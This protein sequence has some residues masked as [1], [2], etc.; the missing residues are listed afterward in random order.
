MQ[1]VAEPYFPKETGTRKESKNRMNPS[2][3]KGSGN[4]RK[5]QVDPFFKPVAWTLKLLGL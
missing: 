4:E 5:S 3:K 1:S 2:R